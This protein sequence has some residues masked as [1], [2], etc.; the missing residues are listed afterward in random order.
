[1]RSTWIKSGVAKLKRECC[2]KKVFANL[3]TGGTNGK[4]R[5]I[6]AAAGH[7][8][9]V[10]LCN[11]L[12]VSRSSYYAYLRRKDV[13]PDADLKEKILA[14]YEQRKKTV[15]Y[16]RIHDELYRQYSLCVNHTVDSNTM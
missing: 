1:V 2:S 5:I 10:E 14:I 15:G 11:T 7:Y 8:P 3:E 16:R 6:K 9:I 13:D 4:Y 12:N